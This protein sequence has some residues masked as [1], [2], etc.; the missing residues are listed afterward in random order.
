[1]S[2]GWLPAFR[3][4]GVIIGSL[5][6]GLSQHQLCMP[7]WKYEASERSSLTYVV[8]PLGLVVMTGDVIILGT[9]G[10]TRYSS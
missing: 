5:E 3:G 9:N 1:M 2:C 6:L 4:D 7:E 10:Y 8:R